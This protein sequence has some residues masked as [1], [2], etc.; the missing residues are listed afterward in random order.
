MTGVVKAVSRCV[1]CALARIDESNE[2][3]GSDW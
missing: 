1:A 2:D 3:A